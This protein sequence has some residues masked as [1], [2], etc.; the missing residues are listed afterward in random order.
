MINERAAGFVDETPS[1]TTYY[2]GNKQCV[3]SEGTGCGMAECFTY[4]LF[5]SMWLTIPQL[6]GSASTQ[7]SHREDAMLYR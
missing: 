6:S 7:L 2:E 3:S 4:L 1:A 5:V